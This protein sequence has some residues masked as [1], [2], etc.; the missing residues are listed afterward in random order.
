MY[1]SRNGRQS[2]KTR[3]NLENN[4][5]IIYYGRKNG[6]RKKDD[7]KLLQNHEEKDDSISSKCVPLFMGRN[8]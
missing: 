7:K 5:M 4:P 6:P 1:K 8:I 2:M 3:I